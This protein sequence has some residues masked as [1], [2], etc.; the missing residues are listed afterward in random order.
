M[1]IWRTKTAIVDAILA[2]QQKQAI[3]LL[4]NVVKIS[5]CHLEWNMKEKH[6]LVFSGASS[7]DLLL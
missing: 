6:L 2:V 4:E 7:K 1:E 3:L 5:T